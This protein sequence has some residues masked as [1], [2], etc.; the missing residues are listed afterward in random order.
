[1]ENIGQLFCNLEYII[2]ENQINNNDLNKEE[3][4]R[5]LVTQFNYYIDEG[6]FHKTRSKRAYD[7]SEEIR[8]IYYKLNQEDIKLIKNDEKKE[9]KEKNTKKTQEIK[10]KYE[11]LEENCNKVKKIKN[12]KQTKFYV[13]H[14]DENDEIILQYFSDNYKVEKKIEKLEIEGKTIITHSKLKKKRKVLKKEESIIS[15]IKINTIFEQ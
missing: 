7:K 10:I 6:N 11:E 3:R 9:K 5:L 4:N 8:E 12:E 1:L 2:G 14:K 13:K 15:N